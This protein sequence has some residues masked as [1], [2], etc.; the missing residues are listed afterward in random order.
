MNEQLYN[1][2]MQGIQYD[3][4]LPVRAV[5]QQCNKLSNEQYQKCLALCIKHNVQKGITE[6]IVGC[7]VPH[8]DDEKPNENI[9][10]APDFICTSDG[11]H[12]FTEKLD[13]M[14][15]EWFIWNH[16]YKYFKKGY[17]YYDCQS[18]IGINNSVKKGDRF[19]ILKL[20]FDTMQISGYASKDENDCIFT[21]I[22]SLEMI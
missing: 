12:V 21:R 14:L 10:E 3:N 2:L 8:P 19:A 5:I 7:R 11:E 20:D 13:D 1:V 18:K 16:K 9:T 4:Y 17:I 22:M 15:K 6:E